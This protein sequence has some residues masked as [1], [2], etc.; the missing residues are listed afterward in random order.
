MEAYM[1]FDTAEEPARAIAMKWGLV[2][3]AIQNF[4][5]QV[6]SIS[7][8]MDVGID[9]EVKLIAVF[10]KNKKAPLSPIWL[11]KLL[12]EIKDEGKTETPKG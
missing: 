11:G 8:Q 12:N 5:N 3:N 9:G 6:K 7:I 1:N 10:L 2:G 4:A